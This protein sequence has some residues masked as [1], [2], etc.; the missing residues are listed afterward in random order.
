MKKAFRTLAV[1]GLLGL[2]AASCTKEVISDQTVTVSETT[3]HYSAG[4]CSGSVTLGNDE[5]WDIF[6]DRMLA[7]AR[8]GYEVTIFS[9][10]PSAFGSSKEVVTYTTTSE[11]DAKAW[12][13]KMTLLGY[14]VRISYDDDTGIYTCT[15]IN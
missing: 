7:L 5:A 6:L 11:D 8:E 13:K 3:V 9:G 1:F 2:A 14:D 12:A 4:D 10:S 15:A